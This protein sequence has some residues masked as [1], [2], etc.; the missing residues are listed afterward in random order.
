MP[1][2][3]KS[4]GESLIFAKDFFGHPAR[5]NRQKLNATVYFAA[6]ARIRRA[7][8]RSDPA[9]GSEHSSHNDLTAIR[10]ASVNAKPSGLRLNTRPVH[11]PPF[12][13]GAYQGLKIF[14]PLSLRF[15]DFQRWKNRD[16]HSMA[17]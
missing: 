11:R 12:S 13:G 15:Q 9:R 5:K 17:D 3:S 16:C 10:E 8:A 7:S 14:T 4:S 2:S 6:Q 1:W